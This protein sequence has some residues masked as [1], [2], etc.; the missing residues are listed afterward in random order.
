M[1]K[2]NF[3]PLSI[4][5]ILVLLPVAVQGT[6]TLAISDA[7]MFRLD[8]RNNKNVDNFN[9]ALFMARNVSL[10][11]GNP[12]HAYVAT[13]KWADHSGGYWY[14]SWIFGMYPKDTLEGFK[15]FFSDEGVAR[16]KEVDAIR[17][18]KPDVVLI[19]Y[20]DNKQLANLY[21]VRTKWRKTQYDGFKADCVS[22]MRDAAKSIGLKVPKRLIISHPAWSL[23]KIASKNGKLAKRDFFPHEN[24]FVPGW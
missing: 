10:I 6:D 13:S 15:S 16:G 11:Q 18:K 7:E 17:D 20:I 9:V 21:A 1:N 14:D 24:G 12:G 8:I 22:F 3:S 4:I 23:K 19:V 2:Y 5:G